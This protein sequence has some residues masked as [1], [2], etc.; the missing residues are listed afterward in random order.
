MEVMDIAASPTKLEN[1]DVLDFL[2][3]ES[4]KNISPI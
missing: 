1:E 3:S 4:Y 2:E